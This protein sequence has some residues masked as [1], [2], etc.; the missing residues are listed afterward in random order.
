MK[1]PSND[2][3]VCCTRAS[4]LAIPRLPH[5][6]QP[7]VV[8]A[9]LQM[10]QTLKQQITQLESRLVVEKGELERSL[11]DSETRSAAEASAAEQQHRSEVGPGRMAGVASHKNARQSHSRAPPFVAWH[12]G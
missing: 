12:A 4:R 6:L 11:K 9:C 1:R 5:P 10:E 3:I 8:L 2:S 7:P